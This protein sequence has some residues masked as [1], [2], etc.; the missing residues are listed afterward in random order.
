MKKTS[1]S[2]EGKEKPTK[3]IKSKVGIA[4]CMQSRL[5][6]IMEATESCVSHFTVTPVLNY[7]PGCNIVECMC[8]LKLSFC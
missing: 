4:T 6:R 2:K 5:D 7:L 3:R 1:S 8:L